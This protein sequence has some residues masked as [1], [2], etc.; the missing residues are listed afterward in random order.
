M[1]YNTSHE[2]LRILLADDDEDDR[3][4]FSEAIKAVNVRHVLNSVEDG[5][6]LMTYKD[7]I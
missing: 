3:E 5:S 4:T 6:K 1:T 2:D 7:C